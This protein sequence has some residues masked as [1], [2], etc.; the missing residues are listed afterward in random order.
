MC[1]KIHKQIIYN[2]ENEM[3]TNIKIIFVDIDWTILSHKD[4]RYFDMES[5]EALKKCQSQG[6]KVF[7]CTSRPYHTVKQL[8]LFDLFTPDGMIVC[9]GGLIIYD[10]K[11]IHEKVMDSSTFEK[12]CE[13]VIKHN[14]NIEA[15]EPYHRFLLTKND[16]DVGKVLSTY[17]ELVP[18]VEDYHNRHII[19]VLL[20]ASEEY[21]EILK[22]EIPQN[23]Y[24]FR[25]HPYG[26]DVLDV[27]HEKGDGVK[28]VLDYLNIKKEDSL[29][30]GDDI[31]DISMFE[32]VG[33]SVALANGRQEAKEKATFVSDEVWNSGVKKA[34][35][36]LDVI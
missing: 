11:I 5:I 36:K 33:I 25:F 12:L 34:L 26:V 14:L 23:L 9:N 16:E 8:G 31:A 6:I 3:N 28:I 21:D 17:P 4:G 7:L 2:L 29:A 30:F 24:Y 27:P 19:S 20:F 13:V 32:N 35:K 22:K 15:V 10:N 18:E 1:L